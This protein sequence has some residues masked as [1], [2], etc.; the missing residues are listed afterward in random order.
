MESRKIW[1]GD[2]T[3]RHKDNTQ[4]YFDHMLNNTTEGRLKNGFYL[5]N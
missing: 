2:N 1:V 5:Y 3:A 4:K